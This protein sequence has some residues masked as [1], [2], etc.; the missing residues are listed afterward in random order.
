MKPSVVSI[1]VPTLNSEATIAKCLTTISKQ[2]YP[3]IE[4][5]VVDNHSVDRTTTIARRFTKNVFIKGPERSTQRNYGATKASG[6]YLCMIDSDME[7]GPNVIQECVDAITKSS[8]VTGVVI[9]EESFGIGFWARCKRLERRFYL[10]VPYIEAARFFLRKN[11]LEVNG[12]D[13]DLISGEDWD[14]SQRISAIGKLARSTSFI[15][16]NEGKISLAKSIRKK[17]YYAKNILPY[18]ASSKSKNVSIQVNVIRRYY[19]FF[20]KPRLLFSNPAVG[21]GMLFMK[22]CEFMFGGAGVILAKLGR[23]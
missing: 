17:F 9:P 18:L 16:H 23:K 22:T 1:I 19:L 6:K 10:D 15:Y 11:F 14:L 21:L 5:V 8:S 13:E 3:A 20:S 12:Y 4:L 2:T 7:L